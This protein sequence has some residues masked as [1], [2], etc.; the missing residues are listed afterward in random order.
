[1][2]CMTGFFFNKDEKE[3]KKD[4]FKVKTS[5]I[6]LDSISSTIEE[7][8]LSQ[9]GVF[10]GDSEEPA[11]ECDLSLVQYSCQSKDGQVGVERLETQIQPLGCLRCKDAEVESKK[12][13]ARIQQCRSMS[14][15]HGIS[16][17]RVNSRNI[18]FEGSR[19][20][21]TIFPNSEHGKPLN[22]RQPNEISHVRL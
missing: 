14:Q 9:G 4:D 19:K 12:F 2:P 22:A 18:F 17:V 11:N 6:G 13:E 1:M 10:P 21:P 7:W 16:I 3:T 8:A 20:S 5:E 15:S